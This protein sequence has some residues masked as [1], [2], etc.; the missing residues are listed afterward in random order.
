MTRDGQIWAGILNASG[1]AAVGY[2]AED[3][4]AKT[5]QP[6]E[7]VDLI[8]TGHGQI[9]A[10]FPDQ[11]RSRTYASKRT[12]IAAVTKWHDQRSRLAHEQG[13][14]DYTTVYGW[15]Q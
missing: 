3:T 6:K 12:A 9:I 11:R 1:H 5:V 15:R 10:K 4:A 8:I 13:V 2:T 7:T 14:T